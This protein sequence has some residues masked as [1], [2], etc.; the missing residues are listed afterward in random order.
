MIKDL[1]CRALELHVWGT[2]VS[3]TVVTEGC[4]MASPSWELLT[5]AILQNGA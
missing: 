2:D 1:L 3:K 4:C 5:R